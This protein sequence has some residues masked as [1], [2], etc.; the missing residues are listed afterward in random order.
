MSMFNVA[1]KILLTNRNVNYVLKK[2]PTGTEVRYFRDGLNGFKKV[3]TKT[4]GDNVVSHLAQ[5]GSVRGIKFINK[6]GTISYSYGAANYDK[7]VQVQPKIGGVFTFLGHK[8]KQNGILYSNMSG[9]YGAG[10]QYMNVFRQ[11][12]NYIKGKSSQ[13][14]FSLCKLNNHV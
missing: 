3:V 14:L 1:S 10:N 4:N 2:L 8:G 12:M 9:Q 7:V 13:Y 11:A 6:K 5:N